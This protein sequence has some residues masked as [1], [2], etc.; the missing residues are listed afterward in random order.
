[1]LSIDKRKIFLLRFLK[2]SREFRMKLYLGWFS[3]V[4][5]GILLELFLKFIFDYLGKVKI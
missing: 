1:M 5:L 4:G 3:K 2:D